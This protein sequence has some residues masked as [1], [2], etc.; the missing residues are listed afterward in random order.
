[1]STDEGSG[2]AIVSRVDT[3]MQEI[4]SAKRVASSARA[5][6]EAAR[7]TEAQE[8]SNVRKHAE[9]KT[10]REL[11]AMRVRL[12]TRGF[13]FARK[14]EASSTKKQREDALIK[15]VL[16]PPLGGVHEA[17]RMA[18]A[19]LRAFNDYMLIRDRARA[20]YARDIKVDTY[21]KKDRRKA[22]QSMERVLKQE[23]LNGNYDTIQK[24]FWC[25]RF[26]GFE[27]DEFSSVQR[28]SHDKGLDYE[29][30]CLA[31]LI[32]KCPDARRTAEGA[33]FGADLLFTYQGTL[34]AGQCK[35]LSKPAGVRAVQEIVAAREHYKATLAVVFSTEG[36]S[37]SAEALAAANRVA[38]VTG[39]DIEAFERQAQLFESMA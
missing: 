28:T 22:V 18:E 3:V 12:E 13:R 20:T 33:D 31:S 38:L 19:F 36:F 11:G 8:R 1:M 9:K 27:A 15:E 34:C 5:A 10:E 35:S 39:T 17:H 25:V 23:G 24:A 26:A 21:G 16:R 32:E 30:R 37:E 7:K 4:A 29:Q 6:Q 14:F 2:K